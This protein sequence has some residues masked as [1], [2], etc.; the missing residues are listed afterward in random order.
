M[1]ELNLIA[2]E[3]RKFF[4]GNTN[5]KQCKCYGDFIRLDIY[6]VNNCPV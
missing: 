3:V 1:K 4:K 5:L 2:K 6:F